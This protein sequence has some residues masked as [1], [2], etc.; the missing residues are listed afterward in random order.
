MGS[1]DDPYTSNLVKVETKSNFDGKFYNFE[2]KRPLNPMKGNLTPA[3]KKR[4][5]DEG[6]GNGKRKDKGIEE[7]N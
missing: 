4:R 1:E 5:L 7:F 6:K 2:V 3:N